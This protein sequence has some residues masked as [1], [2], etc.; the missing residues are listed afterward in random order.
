MIFLLDGFEQLEV[1]L[2]EVWPIQRHKALYSRIRCLGPSDSSE[3]I[4]ERF[5]KILRRH[6]ETCVV[7]CFLCLGL[8]SRRLRF[9]L[10]FF[11]VIFEEISRGTDCLSECSIFDN[12]HGIIIN[13]PNCDKKL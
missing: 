6:Y 2:K 9:C 5:R 3:F 8:W 10:R 7:G 12:K 1:H 13:E 4:R 11:S